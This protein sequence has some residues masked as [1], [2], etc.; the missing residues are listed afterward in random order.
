MIRL[1]GLGAVFLSVTLVVAPLTPTPHLPYPHE[2]LWNRRRMQTQ[3]VS[4]AAAAFDVTHGGCGKDN[5]ET[6]ITL[7]AL[8][9]DDPDTAFAQVAK[10]WE[11]ITVAVLASCEDCRAEYVRCQM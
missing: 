4:C 11:T 1:V 8:T 10:M 3:F 5:L 6:E 7:A 2:P 9:T